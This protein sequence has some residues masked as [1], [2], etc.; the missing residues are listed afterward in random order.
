MVEAST[1]TLKAGFLSPNVPGHRQYRVDKAQTPPDDIVDRRRRGAGAR[2]LSASRQA[3]TPMVF[4]GFPL[5]P[6]SE[7]LHEMVD[8][9]S[10]T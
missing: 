8:R 2:L 7:L 4:A 10:Q 5:T 9:R 6:A 3:K 1:R